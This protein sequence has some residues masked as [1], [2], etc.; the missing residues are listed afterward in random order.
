MLKRMGAGRNM[1]STL[2]R[3]PHAGYGAVHARDKLLGDRCISG[4]HIGTVPLRV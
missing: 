4:F 1:L 2:L 3:S